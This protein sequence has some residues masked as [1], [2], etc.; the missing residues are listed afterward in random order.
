[1]AQDLETRFQ[2]LESLLVGRKWLAPGELDKLADDLF[3]MQQP[4][5]P[6]PESVPVAEPE[7]APVEEEE[8]EPSATV[9]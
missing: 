9:S 4:P 1:M 2:A 8:P 6:E 5:T 3:R 7:P